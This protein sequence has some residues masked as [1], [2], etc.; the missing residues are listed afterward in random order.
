M[1]KFQSQGGLYIYLNNFSPF[2]V[3]INMI[4]HLPRYILNIMKKILIYY[5]IA[6]IIGIIKNIFTYLF[7]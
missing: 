6:L 3:M 1:R 5:N 7:N 4:K 2:L